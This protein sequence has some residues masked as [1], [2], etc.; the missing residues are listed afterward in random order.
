MSVSHIREAFDGL[1]SGSDMVLGPTLNGGYY[2]IGLNRRTVP[3]L[4]SMF[5][6]LEWDSGELLHHQCLIADRIGLKYSV[7]TDKL[8]TID[9]PSDLPEFERLTGVSESDL[10]HPHWTAVLS[11]PKHSTVQQIEASVIK[12]I[13][14]TDSPGN[15]HMVLVY[16][17]DEIDSTDTVTETLKQRI[18]SLGATL[19][20]TSTSHAGSKV[21]ASRGNVVCVPLCE[22]EL[23]MH[24]DSAAHRCL[25]Q[26]GVVAGTFRFGLDVNHDPLVKKNAMFFFQLKSKILEWIINF[27][28]KN[29]EKP[30]IGQPIFLHHSSANLLK[31]VHLS[32]IL[33]YSNTIR[34]LSS[35]G[36]IAV[37]E[38]LCTVSHQLC[39]WKVLIHCGYI[40]V[41]Q[42][43]GFYK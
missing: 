40:S 36:H 29:F 6:G 43:L 1:V 38:E 19:V 37:T 24:W 18:R 2:C 12:L 15:L 34:S 31:D 22:S 21:C 5:L 11:V 41:L 32:T 9:G 7:L 13:E 20:T 42:R 8:S 3:H 27:L 25:S 28:A 23:P 30:V 33:S 14:R 26:P 10:L 17:D 35:C 39:N 16:N 4:P